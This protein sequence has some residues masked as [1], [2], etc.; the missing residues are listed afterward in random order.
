[1]RYLRVAACAAC[2]VVL[3]PLTAVWDGYL[4]ANLY[5]SQWQMGIASGKTVSA[6]GNQF[7]SNKPDPMLYMGGLSFSL[8]LNKTWAFSYQGELGT[9]KADISLSRTYAGP[10]GVPV[11]ETLT[12]RA[13]ILRMDHGLAITRI[14]GTTGINIFVGGKIQKFGYSQSNGSY[15]SSLPS[16]GVLKSDTAIFNFGPAA[17]LAYTFS[18]MR[19]IYISAQGGLIYFIGTNNQDAEL[20]L[21]SFNFKTVLEQ[22]E[23]Y[24]GLGFTG[25]ISVFFAASQRIMVQ[26]SFRTQYYKT[27]TTGLDVAVKQGNPLA[28]N[29]D[30]ADG[31]MNGVVDW[32]MGAQLGVVY[33][34]F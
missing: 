22:R 26:L 5:V 2:F 8:L 7:S 21:P 33:R 34:V 29:P 9:T 24:R 4:G 3:N 23:K 10:G 12:S 19:S 17:G 14:L 20:F 31:A 11:S 1:M 32:Q 28:K 15:V 13:D 6:F 16:T 27:E 30:T 18:V 25:L